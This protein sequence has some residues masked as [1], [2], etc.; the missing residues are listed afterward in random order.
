MCCWLTATG[1]QKL[2]IPITRNSS[3]TGPNVEGGIRDGSWNCNRAP[4]SLVSQ[5]YQMAYLPYV[6]EQIMEAERLN[7]GWPLWRRYMLSEEY[8]NKI[9]HK[10]E[11]STACR[12]SVLA[13]CLARVEGKCV[14]KLFNKVGLVCFLVFWGG[15]FCFIF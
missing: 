14:N 4:R 6:L 15:V 11:K 3:R 2:V 9:L 5:Q 10:K 8:L 13:T 7:I 12:T 1:S